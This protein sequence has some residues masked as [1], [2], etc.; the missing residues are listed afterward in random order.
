MS[1]KRASGL[2]KERLIDD[3]AGWLKSMADP[4]RLRILHALHGGERCVT[5]ILG[6]VRSSQANVSKHLAILKAAGLV[7]CRREG[8]NVYYRISDPSVFTICE[9]VCDSIQ[10]DLDH[11]QEEL[12]RGRS[13]MREGAH[14]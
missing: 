5:D 13:L 10:R 1:A 8:V 2:D 7:D 4:T 9:A 14:A 11:R 3:I 6:A 12:S